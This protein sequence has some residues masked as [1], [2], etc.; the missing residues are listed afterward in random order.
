MRLMLIGDIVG[1]PGRQIVLRA[2]PGLKIDRRIDLV[3]ANAENAAGGSGLTPDI[4]HELIDGGVDCITLGDHA[5][6]RRE[7]YSVLETEPRIVR[8]AN[9]PAQA[10]GREVAVL[11]A[12]AVQVAVFAL[13]GRVFMPPVDCPY[14]AADRVL[15]ALPPDVRV[16]LVDIHAEATSDKQILGRRLDGRVSAVL[17]TH[18]HV[19]TADEQILPG[20]TAFQCDVGMTGPHESILGRRIDRVLETA[21]TFRPT[22]FE[23]ATGDC[24]LCGTIVEVD[25]A[26]GRALHIERVVVDQ[27]EADRLAAIAHHAAVTH[28]NQGNQ[29]P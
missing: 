23:V 8:P 15:G 26:T 10:P 13:L 29:A 25:P 3:V 2:V 7:I 20:G 11:E 17:G 5:Y 1:K 27:H 12:G 21:T 19:A 18:T 28:E 24:R 4:Y 9:Y 14:A 6:R 16:I 22:H